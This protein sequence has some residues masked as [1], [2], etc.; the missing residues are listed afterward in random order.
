MRLT[1]L[2]QTAGKCEFPCGLHGSL[3]TLRMLRSI[4]S[5]L[6]PIRTT[7]YGWVASPS[8]T[9]SFTLQETPSCAWRTN[10]TLQAREMAAARDE[11]R[12][13]PVAWMRLLDRL[14]LQRRG[15]AFLRIFC[16]WSHDARALLTSLPPLPILPPTPCTPHLVMIPTRQNSDFVLEDFIH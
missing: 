5:Y 2:D 1:R 4:L 12:L 7:R 16:P 14:R 15:R 13:F 6:L 11:R 9:G 10:A 3:C 8:P